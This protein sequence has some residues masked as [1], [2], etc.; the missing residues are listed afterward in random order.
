M[1]AL[2][3]EAINPGEDWLHVAL[4]GDQANELYEKAVDYASKQAYLSNGEPRPHLC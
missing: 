1:I 4:I 2:L 3:S